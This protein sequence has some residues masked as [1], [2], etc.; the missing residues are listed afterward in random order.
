MPAPGAT[1]FMTSS[2][3]WESGE[4]GK[5]CLERLGV[6]GGMGG[7]GPSGLTREQGLRKVERMEKYLAQGTIINV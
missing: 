4:K 2:T 7:M 3:E 6:V 5:M 1:L